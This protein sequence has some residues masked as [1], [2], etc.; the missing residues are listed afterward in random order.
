MSM[1]K[2]KKVLVLYSGGRDSSA[3]AVELAR[4]GYLVKLFTYQAGLSELTGFSGDSAPDVRHKELLKSFPENIDKDRIIEDNIYLI[5]K[6]AIEKTNREHVVYPI[7]LALAVH[8][9]AICYCLKN[10]IEIMASGYSGYQS[11]K[12]NYI[13]Q[14]GD[15]VS[16]NKKFLQDYGI[17]YLT[18]VIEKSEDEIKDI[19]EIHDVSSNSLENKS[20]F[21]GIYFDKEKA[22]EFWNLSI[23]ICRE[24]IKNKQQNFK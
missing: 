20:V 9:N 18:P 15:F 5:R 24:F 11:K 14:R 13:E 17:S 7:A 19:L 10:G 6:L 23:P 2:S 22:L 8:S 4:K 3:T 12:D 16:L 21:G 1:D